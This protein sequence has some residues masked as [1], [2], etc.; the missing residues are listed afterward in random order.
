MLNDVEKILQARGF[1]YKNKFKD[2]PEKDLYRAIIDG[3]IYVVKNF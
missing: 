3:K 2:N 1:Y